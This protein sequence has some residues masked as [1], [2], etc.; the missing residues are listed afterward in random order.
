MAQLADNDVRKE[1]TG[2][3]MIDSFL[4]AIQTRKYEPL[5]TGIADID[6]AIG[7]GFIR[8][9][10]ILLGAAPG[11]GKTAMAQWIFEGMAK[12]GI[13]SVYLNLEMSRDQILARSFSRITAQH[14]ARIKA[15]DILQGY[16]WTEEQRNAI[17][18]AA[19]EYK[20]DI[21]PF[22]VYNPEGV[23]PTLEAVLAYI[24]KEARAA[25]QAERAAPC[26][27]IDY[28]QIIG[29]EDK[30]EEPASIIKRA[31]SSLKDY[32]IKHN[33]IVF[34]IMANNRESNRSGDVTMESGRDTSA[35]EYGADLQLGL[36]LTACLKRNGQKAKAKDELTQEERKRV[37]L[38]V[39]KARFANPNA[40]VDLIFDGETMTYTQVAKE[41]QKR[42]TK[43]YYDMEIF[44]R[45][46]NS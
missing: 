11:A 27:V 16:K 15:V 5:P 37:T 28:L 10:L 26:V 9:Q 13:S 14:G 3:G 24:E 17:M 2:S 6:K 45:H 39:T 18:S 12:R 1:R 31:M 8:Q 30:R 29:S 41:N 33:T 44:D 19:E 32:A 20:R 43:E 7:G 25:E 35:I 42:N 40:E 36:A 22:M 23:S 46:R 4:E 34:V 38:K 21:A